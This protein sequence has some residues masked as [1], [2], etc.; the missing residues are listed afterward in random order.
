MAGILFVK[1]QTVRRQDDFR[2][3]KVYNEKLVAN[4]R[5]ILGYGN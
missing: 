4:R 5:I 3:Y 1:Y 2:G